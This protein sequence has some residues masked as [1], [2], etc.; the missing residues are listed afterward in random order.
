MVLAIA[1]VIF[2]LAIVALS[3]TQSI[4]LASYVLLP[5]FFLMVWRGW[6]TKQLLQYCIIYCGAVI[7]AIASMT[8]FFM[9]YNNH[10]LA[11][12]QSL[13]STSPSWY[14]SLIATGTIIEKQT[15]NRYVRQADNG[16]R[17]FLYTDTRYQP[18]DY[19]RL[20]A[21]ARL[22]TY[23]T[24]SLFTQHTHKKD[25]F[26]QYWI[27]YSFDFSSRQ[28]MKK[29][30]GS[31]YER[32]SIVLW[33]WDITI[34]EQ[35]RFSLKE[36]IAQ[37]FSNDSSRWLIAGM[38]LWDRSLLP[39]DDYQLFI[40]S[41]I[42]HIIAVSGA[43]MVT[44]VLFLQLILFFVPFY[45]RIAIII[46]CVIFYAMLCG[47]DGS[48]MR[49]AIMGS[50]SL[51]ALFRGKQTL[52]WRSL[53]IAYTVM[54]LVNPLF[55]VYDIGFIFSFAA[56]VGIVYMT[57]WTK[58]WQLPRKWH[59]S[60]GINYV[61]RSYAIPS[62]WASMTIIP[63]L[64]FFTGKFNL[65]SIVANILIFP[66]VPFV[67]IGGA[68]TTA[69]QQFV[70]G[71][72]LWWL[73]QWGI[74]YLYFIANLGQKYGIYIMSQ[75]HWFMYLVLFVVIILFIVDRCISLQPSDKK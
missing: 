6:K 57:Q 39:A 23:K 60:S 24:L 1:T 55:L 19:I 7:L 66:L 36:H 14:Q 10:V 22:S 45:L 27:E 61:L 56:V 69:L 28:I 50:L 65:I 38:L 29:V 67:M 16:V 70:I 72:R 62:L 37:T 12:W 3:T 26:A 21:N 5:L 17:F 74:E 4:V 68:L 33:Q 43:H 46:P 64:L 31:L 30:A 75:G 47:L 2:S 13:I 59:I 58:D 40:D 52:V 42:V 73:V 34:I 35:R 41:G 20:T 25:R 48:V 63:F 15:H 18:G 51:L 32:N 11:P 53:F 49:A 71:S 9:R 54:I 44:V 8:V